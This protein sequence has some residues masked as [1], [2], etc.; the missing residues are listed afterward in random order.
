MSD[1][2]GLPLRLLRSLKEGASR[3]SLL[4]TTSHRPSR[5][6][7]SFIKDLEGVIGGAIR[8]TR[9]HLSLRDLGVIGARLGVQRVLVVF[10][11]N[12]NPGLLVGYVP[13]EEGLSELERLKVLGVTLSR[14]LRSRARFKCSSVY[15]ADQASRG[16]AEAL[17]KITGL[18]LLEEPRGNYLE[19]R[20]EG[21]VF[22][23]VPRSDRAFTGP[24][25]RLEGNQVGGKGE[26]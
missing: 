1:N 24:I 23:V 22:V 16:P 25:I 17:A 20:S 7:R 8:L 9:G 12:G 13:D 11:R 21:E 15:A 14:E 26:G 3:P 18:Q 10:E 6:T 19:V 2:E 5:R 4:I